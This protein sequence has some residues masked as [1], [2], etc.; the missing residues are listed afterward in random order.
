MQLPSRSRAVLLV[1]TLGACQQLDDADTTQASLKTS[2]YYTLDQ[3]RADLAARDADRKAAYVKDLRAQTAPADWIAY[4]YHGNIVDANFDPVL[5]DAP[6]IDA[7]QQS[8]Y[9]RLY[10]GAGK[11]ATAKYGDIAKLFAAQGLNPRERAEARET[12]LDGLLSV[13]TQAQVESLKWRVEILRGGIA[14]LLWQYTISPA[15]LEWIRSHGIPVWTPPPG[16]DYI[17][18]CRAQGVPIPPDW[19]DP[20]W[21]RQGEL[22]FNFLNSVHVDVHTYTDPSRPDY[23]GICYALPRTALDGTLTF[24]GM[25]CQNH[26]NG[27]AC[28][29]DNVQ[30][31]NS[32]R[33][34][35]A[36]YPLR[37]GYIGDGYTLSETCTDCHRGDNV[38]NIHPGTT[39]DVD[40][41][42]T[43]ALTRFSPIGRPGYANPPPISLAPPPSGQRACNGCHSL[44]RVSASY[45]SSVL[46]PAARYTMP[47]GWMFEP[48]AMTAGWTPGPVRADYDAHIAALRTAC[49]TAP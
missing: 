43:S 27:K 8:I 41:G 1:A 38:F 13:A 26:L 4:A 15:V 48:V 33:L 18:A 29:W 24:I 12:A 35:P 19:P 42:W 44:P 46:E 30:R 11:A 22:A 28:F 25:I 37:I 5:L 23:A 45:C 17:D 32:R 47:E 7:I 20:Q 9:D 3:Q 6:T 21:Y 2:D 10:P 31:D 16:K 39:L 40:R 36:D 49:A 14:S 34:Y